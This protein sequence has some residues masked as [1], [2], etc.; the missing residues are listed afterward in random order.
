LRLFEVNFGI[1]PRLDAPHAASGDAEM[2]QQPERL[3]N[4]KRIEQQGS[5]RLRIRRRHRSRASRPPR[6]HDPRVNDSRLGGARVVIAPLTMRRADAWLVAVVVAATV[7]LCWFPSW[8][9]SGAFLLAGAA[10]LL[11]WRWTLR[12]HD[13][14]LGERRQLG[15]QI[16]ELKQ[17]QARLVGNIAHELKTPLAVVLGEAEQ[18]LLRCDDAVAVHGIAENIAAEVRHL[19]YLVDAYLQITPLLVH[20]DTAAHVSVF[21]GDVVIEAVGRCGA[22]GRQLGVRVVTVL[23]APDN[24]DPSAEVLGDPLLLVMLVE[25]LLRYALRSSPPDSQVELL[26]HADADAV[27]I[28]VRDHGMGIPA[29]DQELVFEWY[30]E[31]RGPSPKTRGSGFGL[32]IA[33]AVVDHHGGAITLRDTSGGGCEF[34]IVL[35]RH[36]PVGGQTGELPAKLRREPPVAPAA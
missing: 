3:E 32:A 19:S 30:F 7:G 21:V 22:L 16:D 18:L 1:L 10:V 35:P 33:K 27:G 2:D 13:R 29:R 14:M 25:H 31:G 17:Q 24:G 5:W 8:W 23:A 4:G 34:V 20:E 36:W 12:R 6:F 11:D 15:A 9:M 28:V 26:T